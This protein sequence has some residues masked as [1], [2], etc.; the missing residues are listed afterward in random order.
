MK[1]FLKFFTE[2]ANKFAPIFIVVLLVVL[3]TQFLLN[4][5]VHTSKYRGSMLLFL[6]MQVGNMVFG[7]LFLKGYFTKIRKGQFDDP[8]F[9]FATILML[10]GAASILLSL[11]LP[12]NFNNWSIRIMNYWTLFAVPIVTKEVM[13]MHPRWRSILTFVLP[14]VIIISLINISRDQTIFGYP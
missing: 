11:F 7:A 3:T 9:R 14:I 6:F 8:F 2:H 4:R 10:M 12:I 1:H 5:D 13:D